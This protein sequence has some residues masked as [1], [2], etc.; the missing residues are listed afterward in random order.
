M[1]SGAHHTPKTH[2]RHPAGRAAAWMVAGAFVLIVAFFAGALYT[3][4]PAFCLTCHEMGPYY[5]AWASGAHSEVSCIRCHVDA[6]ITARLAHKFEALGEVRSHIRGDTRFPRPTPADVTSDRCSRCHPDMP[7]TTASGFPHGAHARV[8]P[9]A[10]C[11]ADTGHPVTAKALQDAGIH[12]ATAPPTIPAGAVAAAGAGVANVRGH[13]VVDCAECH[14]LERTG[15]PACHASE[16]EPRGD[17]MLCH[18]TGDT[19]RFSHPSRGVDCASCHERPDDHIDDGDCLHCHDKPG[20]SWAHTHS[21][22]EDCGPCHTAPDD[23]P[24]G[25]CID[26]H[27]RAGKSW[28][29]AHPGSKSNCRTCHTAPSGHYAGSCVRC[30]RRV[31]V[32]F[33]FSHPSAGEHSWRSQP[34]KKCHPSETASVS[35]TCHGGRPPR[36]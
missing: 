18:R 30:H 13:I 1:N 14:D 5:E 34:C 23:H 25:D 17:C 21:S 22:G 8:G 20:R 35:C 10:E 19:W 32:T 11:H 27:K 36:D 2:T 3:D 33:A 7:V 4:R 12:R 15:C 26:C 28:A 31:G 6:G 24:Q 16:H 9:C 29:F